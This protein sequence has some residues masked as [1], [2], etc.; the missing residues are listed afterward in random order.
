MGKITGI[1]KIMGDF[2]SPVP[3]FAWLSGALVAVLLE[4]LTGEDL[5]AFL[6]LDKIPVLFGCESVLSA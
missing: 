6:G 2:F 1:G 5:S 4:H 3:L